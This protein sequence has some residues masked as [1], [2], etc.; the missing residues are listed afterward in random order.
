MTADPLD[1]AGNSQLPAIA[2]VIMSGGAGT[3]LW[4]LS[5]E[6]SPKQFHPLTSDRTMIQET[7]LR[8]RAGGGLDFA[9]PIVICNRLHVREVRAQLSAVGIEPSLIVAEP[10][11]RNT[12]VVA[13]IA[14][15]LVA[16]RA[17]SRLV[18]L[19]PAD[20]LIADAAGFV[21]AVARGAS[22]HGRI[23]TF[24]I[25]PTEP[26]EGYGYI[27][28]AEMIGGGVYGVVRFVEKPTRT[29]AQAYLSDGGYYWNGGIFLFAPDV[30]RREFDRYRPDVGDAAE[31]ALADA[32]LVDGVLELADESFA[33]APSVSL[34]VAVMERTRLAAVVPCDMGWADIG[35]WT[36]LWRLGAHDESRNRLF[37]DVVALETVNSLVWSD[38][39]AV[40][41]IGLDDVVVV[42]AHGAVLVASKSHAQAVRGIAERL[43]ARG[44]T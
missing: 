35:S 2:P 17:P 5:T 42:A 31:A 27:Q 6:D 7:A 11:G 10:F 1:P 44:R 21:A 40:G 25:E 12:A 33:R 32:R 41:V 37:G 38:G 24:G 26:H 18:L 8:A 16:E 23:V 20:H 29:V 39:P 36:E 3:R 22:A 13:A 19:Q 28:R 43:A 34:D 9:A 15:R 14:A 30:M 4:P